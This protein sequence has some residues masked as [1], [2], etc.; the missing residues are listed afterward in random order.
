MLTSWKVLVISDTHGRITRAAML[1]RALAGAID[2]V[3]FLGDHIEDGEELSRMFPRLAFLSVAG[4]CDYGRKELSREVFV[5]G[6]RMYLCHGHR[7]GVK[8][9]YEGLEAFARRHKYDIV[10]CGHTHK[11]YVDAQEDLLILNPGSISMPVAVY[12]ADYA[13]LK[14]EEGKRPEYRFGDASEPV[15]NILHFLYEK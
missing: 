4:N 6:H 2:A 7:Y 12:G 10:L 5:L 11:P 13:V 14:L 1:I 9:G 15:Q 8:E 3:Y